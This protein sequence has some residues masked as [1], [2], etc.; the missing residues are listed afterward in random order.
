MA[1]EITDITERNE[2]RILSEQEH[3]LLEEAVILLRSLDG[4]LQSLL[5]AWDTGGARGARAA[6]RSLRRPSAIP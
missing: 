3:A 2:G 6:V 5:A 4:A 1:A